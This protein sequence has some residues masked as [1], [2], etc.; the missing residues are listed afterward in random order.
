MAFQISNDVVI[1]MYKTKRQLR[2]TFLKYMCLTMIVYLT[3]DYGC[4]I[5]NKSDN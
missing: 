2:T 5:T 3:N 1:K 4:E